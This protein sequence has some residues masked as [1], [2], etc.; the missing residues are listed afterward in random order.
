MVSRRERIWLII[1]IV[2]AIV[3]VFM[4]L[5]S[6]VRIQFDPLGINRDVHVRPGLD[7]SGG[8][9]VLLQATDCTQTNLATSL[10]LARQIIEKRVNGLG[11]TEALVQIQGECRILIELP[12][13]DNPA[14]ALALIQQTG[15]LEFVDANADSY[16]DGTV[17]RTTGNP[18]PTL[19]STVTPISP[20]ETL[21]PTIPGL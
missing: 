19:P 17:I 8:S 1:I 13:S 18:S 14:D 5:P 6:T 10:D 3:V 7:L 12:A 20:T 2:L 11:V 4:A 16:T 15:R 9:Q 21:S